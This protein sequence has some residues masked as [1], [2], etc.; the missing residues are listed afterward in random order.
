MKLFLICVALAIPGLCQA[1]LPKLLTER[2]FTSA[3]LAEAA[4]HYVSIGEQATF[5]E[6]EAFIAEDP[7]R[8]NHHLARGYS[9]DERIAWI[10]RIIYVPKDPV[11]MHV[12]KTGQWIPGSIV[13][14]R[15]PDFGF[16]ELPVGSMP[17]ERWP[18]YPLA[19]SGS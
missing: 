16:L 12:A 11:P 1:E 19:L 8:T 7:A 2:A 10:F 9:V 17:A 5:K 13:Q 15:P 3:S 18:L 6:L 14:L 4:N